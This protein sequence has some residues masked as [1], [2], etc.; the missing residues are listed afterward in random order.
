MRAHEFVTEWKIVDRMMT[1]KELHMAVRIFQNIKAKYKDAHQA[2]SKAANEV[3]VRP[4]VLQTYLIDNGLLSE[5]ELQEGELMEGY[6]AYTLDKK[7][8]NKL[9]SIFPPK[10]PEFIG[11][12]ITYKFGVGADEKLP[13]GGTFKVVGYADDGKGLEALVVEVN[14]KTQ[15]PDGKIYHITWSLD[16]S[17]G[18]KPVHSNNLIASKGFENVSPVGIM[19]KSEM[20]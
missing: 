7:S 18:R 1:G 5:A 12:H 2:V 15:R 20:L 6:I 4:R 3:G 9:K 14:G 10:Y 8:R 17:K 11:H 13:K 19:A 16:R